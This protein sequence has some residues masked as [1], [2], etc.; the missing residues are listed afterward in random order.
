[1]NKA[2]YKLNKSD[3]D[4]D[5]VFFM[6]IRALFTIRNANLVQDIPSDAQHTIS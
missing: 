2:E 3:E 1:M 6:F 4:Y 5:K